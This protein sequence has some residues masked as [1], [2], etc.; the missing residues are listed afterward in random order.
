MEDQE[1]TLETP[2]EW[3]TPELNKIDVEEAASHLFP[4]AEEDG[5]ES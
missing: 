5:D 1:E 2:K 3:V 4:F